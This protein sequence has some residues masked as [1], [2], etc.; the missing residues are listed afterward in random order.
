MITQRD[1]LSF[2]T[3]PIGHF[4]LLNPTAIPMAIGFRTLNYIIKNQLPNTLQLITRRQNANTAS[5]IGPP[6][7]ASHSESKSEIMV[8]DIE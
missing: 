3:N 2:I 6:K 7:L 5:E 8:E 4:M 1:S